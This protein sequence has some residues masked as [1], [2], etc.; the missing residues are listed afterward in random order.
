MVTNTVQ[1]QHE[2]EQGYAERSGVTIEWLHQ[3]GQHAIPCQCG[4]AGCK[5]WQMT[6]QDAHREGRNMPGT[7]Y[8]HIS[9][10]ELRKLLHMPKETTIFNIKR[11]DYH[12]DTFTFVIQHPDLPIVH[13]GAM[14]PEITPTLWWK[15]ERGDATDEPKGPLGYHDVE[16]FYPEDEPEE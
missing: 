8:F 3:Q 2:F 9:A 14:T 15:W 13:E 12:P 5:G 6:R 11:H 16:D 10:E 7:A 4:E 1:T